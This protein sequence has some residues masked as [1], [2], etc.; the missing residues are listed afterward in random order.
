MSNPFASAIQVLS[1]EAE[2]DRAWGNP[3]NEAE[4]N[5]AIRVL[6]TAGERVEELRESVRLSCDAFIPLD[7]EE[8]A[9]LLAILS[10]YSSLRAENE[11]LWTEN[12]TRS[13]AV[14]YG[15]KARAEKAEAELAKQGPLIQAAMGATP[16][17]GMNPLQLEFYP[18]D[19]KNILRAALA[20]REGKK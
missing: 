1:D 18:D 16:W 10:D 2:K 14:R 17:G 15:W 9:D 3:E 11:R 5:A 12:K 19:A 4:F 8:C 6:E 7:E 20:L 13:S